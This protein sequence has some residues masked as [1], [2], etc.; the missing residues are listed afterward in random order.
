M[1]GKRPVSATTTAAT[2]TP[3]LP[4]PQGK[5][6]PGMLVESYCEGGLLLE[7]RYGK[8]TAAGD[9]EGYRKRH[10]GMG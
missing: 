8:R 6:S 5:L 3:P 1:T 4:P 7:N 2:T 9:Y 10:E